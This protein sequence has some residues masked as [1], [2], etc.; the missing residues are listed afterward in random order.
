LT[1][2]DG[3]V[4]ANS[5]VGAFDHFPA[6]T[7]NARAIAVDVTGA[8]AIEGAGSGIAATTQVG[9]TGNAGSVTV[10]A[11]R[12]TIAAGG[13]VASTTAGTGAGGSV[14][15]TTLGA[16][17]LDGAGNAATKIA[18]SVTV[19][20]SGPGGNVTVAAGSLTIEGG[21]GIASSSNGNGDAGSVTVNADRLLLNG[22]AA[23]STAARRAS[24]GDIALTVGDL[25]AL[26]GGEVTTSVKGKTANSNGGNI[27][28][29]S[30]LTVLDHAS[31][32]A[33]AVA[34]HGG[35]ITINQDGGAFIASA[36]PDSVVSATSQKGI[37]GVVEIDGPG[38]II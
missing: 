25:L 35:A 27:V 4:I 22:S 31:I 33:E 26:V 12:I 19:P 13:E 36:F 11:G 29:A 38:R 23:I 3:G 34:G 1:L 14:V 16:L 2:V 20:Q 8:L 18:A 10:S 21:A 28:I 37:S 6:S 7:G 9:T 5:A 32:I 30:G 24:G 15:V 17:V